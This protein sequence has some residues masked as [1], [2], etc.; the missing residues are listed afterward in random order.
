MMLKSLQ[1]LE[2]LRAE[3]KIYE[4]D[5]IEIAYIKRAL[6]LTKGNRTIACALLGIGRTTMGRFIKEHLK[7]DVQNALDSSK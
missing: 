4:L 3:L 7:G 5:R 2:R 1:N 6:R